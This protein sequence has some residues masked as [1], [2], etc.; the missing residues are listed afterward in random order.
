MVLLKI[1][2]LEVIACTALACV[3]HAFGEPPAPLDFKA[4]DHVEGAEKPDSPQPAKHKAHCRAHV[5]EADDRQHHKGSQDR[6]DDA[7]RRTAIKD[8]ILS[9]V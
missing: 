9:D 4:P 2:I 1:M 8:K 7:G 6:Q 5:Y 3:P